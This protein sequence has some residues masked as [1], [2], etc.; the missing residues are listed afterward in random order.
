[1]F[2]LKAPLLTVTVIIISIYIALTMWQALSSRFIW[3]RLVLISYPLS[4]LVNF[5]LDKSILSPLYRGGDWGP[6]RLP[7]L[8]RLS[9]L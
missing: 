2:M 1:M 5:S 4:V 7:A 9:Q 8:P 6:E 3:I